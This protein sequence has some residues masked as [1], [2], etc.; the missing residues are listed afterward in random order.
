MAKGLFRVV[1]QLFRSNRTPSSSDELTTSQQTG[2]LAGHVHAQVTEQRNNAVALEPYDDH[3]ANLPI[4]TVLA[5]FVL[6]EDVA[7]P[8]RRLTIPPRRLEDDPKPFDYLH[9]FNADEQPRYSAHLQFETSASRFV[10]EAKKLID[11]LELTA[12]PCPFHSYYSTYDD[13]NKDQRRWY[14]YWRNQVRQKNYPDT[15]LSY[16]FVHAY[17]LINGIGVP[18]PTQ[19]LNRLIELW[20]AYHSRYP[21]LSYY[22]RDWAEDY[23]ILHGIPG[24]IER[25]HTA[26]ATSWPTGLRYPDFVIDHFAKRRLMHMPVPMVG[27]LADVNLLNSSFVRAGNEKLLFFFIALALDAVDEVV[28]K[29]AGKGIFEKYGGE[30]R[31]TV[32]RRVFSSAVFDGEQREIE[33]LSPPAYEHSAVLQKVLKGIVKHTENCLREATGSRNRLRSYT[34]SEKHRVIVEQLVANQYPKV[35]QLSP[36]THEASQKATRVPIPPTSPVLDIDMSM[37]ASLRDQS[38]KVRS[39]LLVDD[40]EEREEPV[41]P[42]QSMPALVRLALESPTASLAQHTSLPRQSSIGMWQELFCQLSRSQ[43]AA[44]KAVYEGIDPVQAVRQIARVEGQMPEQYLDSINEVAADVVGDAVIDLTETV[45][46][47]YEDYADEVGT[48]LQVHS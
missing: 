43:V 14:F 6:S 2:H 26:M 20:S 27:Q 45:P 19:G 39:M 46:K 21:N 10:R 16:V 1:T 22:L 35:R 36:T 41:Q 28:K 38:L 13:M 37:V 23:A 3:M 17:E 5:E 12:D 44:L 7:K 47:L 29:R 31:R 25:L 40:D 11:H 34:I 24:G 48:L 30:H 33:I 42:I 4:E 32:K 15:D 8:A 9:A 18:E